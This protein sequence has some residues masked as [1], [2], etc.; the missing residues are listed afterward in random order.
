MKIFDKRP[1]A[2]ILCI[3]LVGFVAFSVGEVWLKICALAIIPLLLV[4]SCFKVDLRRLLIGLA[5]A[6]AI[7]VLFSYVY[8]DLIFFPSD[9]F[10]GDQ[11]IVGTV[12]EIHA[13]KN[14]GRMIFETKSISGEDGYSYK[15]VMNFEQDDADKIKSGD[16]IKFRGMINEFDSSSESELRRYYT[17]LGVSGECIPSD[18][19]EVTAKGEPP[20]QIRIA[21]FRENLTRRAMMLSDNKSGKL[22]SAILFGE[23]DVLDGKIQL[24]FKRIGVTH[25][26][27]LSG[28]HTAILALGITKLL[29]FFGIGKRTSSIFVL[30]FTLF[31][32]VLT[33][34]PVSVVRAGIMLIIATVL[35]LLV[36]SRDS[37]TSLSISAFLICVFDPT[38]IYDISLWLSVFATMGIIVFSEYES[39]KIDRRKRLYPDQKPLF[40]RILIGFYSWCKASIF[41][42]YFAIGCTL[43]LSML[44]FGS[45]SVMSAVATLLLTPFIT[46]FMYIGAMT[47]IFGAIIPFGI[48]L[49]PLTYII[50]AIS[51]WLSSFDGI[52][53]S[54]N[55]ALT[56][57]LFLLVTLIL[58]LFFTLDLGKR[59]RRIALVLILFLLTSSYLSAYL[60]NL[61]ITSEE[62]ILYIN[63]EKSSTF[64]FKSDGVCAVLCSSSYN[65]LSSKYITAAMSESA[66]SELDYYM[67]THYGFG[68]INHIKTLLAS[69]KI[70]AL[71]MPR[72][73]NDE[74]RAILARIQ[75]IAKEYEAEIDYFESKTAYEIGDLGVTLNHS[76]K[77]G[78]DTIRTAFTV[79]DGEVKYTYLSS[80]MLLDDF[81]NFASKITLDSDVI[82]FGGHGKSYSDT[83]NIDES[84]VNTKTFILC[85]KNLYFTQNAYEIYKAKGC[86]IYSHPYAISIL[87]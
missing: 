11:E 27:A 84:F 7:S 25:I 87:K 74:E 4:F 38:S 80:G 26:L 40:K 21:E 48:F 63:D 76:T 55:Y 70:K 72:P 31:Y 28:M 82:I 37:F 19:I 39:S 17:S 36:G 41:S 23:R 18:L 49:S 1:L 77:Y 73:R 10:I 81:K 42:S 67:V 86:K 29:A 9:K 78:Q 51:S 5:S 59:I 62:D 3:F 68:L 14:S 8:F 20:M 46:L 13:D 16:T 75:N 54:A 35:F 47:L 45:I 30:L 22:I 64:V 66:L 79:E 2:S 24:D 71:V 83:V 58:V 56:L 50:E 15:F 44:T 33:G 12:Y 34:F 57:I 60:L 32:I 43:L 85:S 6:L 69:Y 65:D 53:I 61:S 52:Y